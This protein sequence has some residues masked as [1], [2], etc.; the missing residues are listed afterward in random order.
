[1]SQTLLVADDDPTIRSIV[2]ATVAL[3]DFTVLQAAEGE[4]A[5]A[6]ILQHK[7]ATVLLDVDMPGRTGLDLVRM[8][9]AEPSLVGTRVIL[10]TGRGL[11]SDVAAGRAAG[12]DHYL[13]K[14]FSP[15]QLLNLIAD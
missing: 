4:T 5:W 15:L 14:P 11:D 6:L 2:S 1:M 7:P 9:R 10:L 13:T 8:I 12:A 3:D